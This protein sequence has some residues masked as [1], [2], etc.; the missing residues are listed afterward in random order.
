MNLIK[1]VNQTLSDGIK[2]FKKNKPQILIRGG[3]IVS[4]AGTVTACAATYK[5]VDRILDTT[6][7]KLENAENK[8]EKR[9]AVGYCAA[10]FAKAFALPAVLTAVGYTSIELGNREHEKIENML[11][12]KAAT[13]AAS[14]LTLRKRMEEKLGKEKAD[15]IRF[16]VDDVKETIEIEK[17]GKKKKETTERKEIDKETAL[18][19]SPFAF[20]FDKTTSRCASNIGDPVAD[21]EYNT[22][23]VMEMIKECQKV[24]NVSGSEMLMPFI[25]DKLDLQV[26]DAVVTAGYLPGDE[27]KVNIVDASKWCDSRTAKYLTDCIL[28][29][30]VNCRPDLRPYLSKSSTKAQMLDAQ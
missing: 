21:K 3:M 18:D 5:H 26:T 27:I 20:F 11:T 6:K 16:G 19:A 22:A 28:V 23:Y 25:L 30:F 24:L 10:E 7:Q 1:I 8:K 9:Q 17:N 2:F 14:Y 12:E 13:F 4:A 29:E 15:E